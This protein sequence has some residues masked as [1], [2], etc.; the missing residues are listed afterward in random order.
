VKLRRVWPLTIFVLGAIGAGPAVAA[1]VVIGVLEN[2]SPKQ[3]TA[4]ERDFGHMTGAVARLAFRKEAGQWQA[5]KSDFDDVEALKSATADFPAQMDW[6]IA[7]AGKALGRVKST[8]PAAWNGY[9]EVGLQTFAA[10]WEPPRIGGRSA[11]FEQWNAGAPVYRPLVLVSTPSVQDPDHWHAIAPASSLVREA[12]P[13][14]REAIRQEDSNL[15][16]A[17]RDV[18]VVEAYDSN[19]GRMMF[20]LKLRRAAARDEVPGP[21]RSLHWFA[22]GPGNVV[23]FLGSELAYIDA[24]DYDNDGHSEILFMKSSDN[25]DGYV[26]FADNFTHSAEFS[27][28]YH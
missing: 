22:S 28:V 6:T 9:A 2:L 5:F 12:M 27:W 26:L 11:A 15:I 21:E 24:G 20:A 10:G 13:A 3:R 1:D 8:S 14:L 25:R 4:L 17:D 18:R 19:T 16:L 23:K 7:Y